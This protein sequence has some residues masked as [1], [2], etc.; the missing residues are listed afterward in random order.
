MKICIQ[1]LCHFLIHNYVRYRLSAGSQWEDLYFSF[2][3]SD[4]GTNII[5]GSQMVIPIKAHARK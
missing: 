1:I 3:K 5:E 2:G 4:F